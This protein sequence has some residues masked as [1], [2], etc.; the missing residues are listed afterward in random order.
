MRLIKAEAER[1]LM[2]AAH[3]A[4]G[5]ALVPNPKFALLA[6]EA[7]YGDTS[8]SIEFMQANFPAWRV[9]GAEYLPEVPSRN[10]AMNQVGNDR[11]GQDYDD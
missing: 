10:P 7:V 1:E 6:G 9:V 3:L 4:Y 5:F 2:Q 8:M 11:R